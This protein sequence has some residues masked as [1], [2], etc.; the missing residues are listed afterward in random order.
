MRTAISTVPDF[1]LRS[2]RQEPV[3]AE[4]SL[5][6]A[7]DDPLGYKN[8]LHEVIHG[9]DPLDVLERT[10]L[11]CRSHLAPLPAELLDARPAPGEWSVSQTVAH[12]FD[13]DMVYG[14]RWRLVLTEDSPAYPGYDENLW[15][16]LPRL[17][18]WQM[19]DAWEGLRASNLALLRQTATGSWART[20]VHAEQ[21]GEDFDEMVKKMAAHDLAHINQIERTI[22]QVSH[23]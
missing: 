9:R 12:L 8:A 22:A 10:T 6:D 1:L 5:P 7:K 20:G 2:E 4:I 19:V 14:F 11:E 15:V 13:V 23:G 18:F 16:D 17:D 21:G 3:P